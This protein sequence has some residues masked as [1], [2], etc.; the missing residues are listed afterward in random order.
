M[1][2]LT[3]SIVTPSFNQVDYIEDTIKSV[4]FQDHPNIEHIIMD[5]GSNDGTIDVLREYEGEY[6]MTWVSQADKG[7]ADAINK[8]FEK[9]SGD[10]LGWLNSDDVYLSKSVIS[11]SVEVLERYPSAD[12]VNG[13]GIRL[14]EDGKW[15]YPIK[16]RDHKLSHSDLKQVASVLQP[17]TFWY[18]YVWESIGIDDGLEYTFD[19]DFF[20]K[21]TR[22]YNLVPIPDYLIGY[23]WQGNNKTT[24][25]GMKRAEEIREITG[26]YLGHSS[27]QY[28]LLCLYCGIY[29]VSNHLPRFMGEPIEEA[30]DFFSS[31]VSYLS[32]KQVSGV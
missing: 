4:K 3:V 27:W 31:A 24:T 8:G 6:N 16:R 26:K 21:A 11:H 17:A 9:A 14:K 10:V 20:I 23:R 5:G 30:L 22:Y 19:W 15:D 25:G 12:L 32:L 1:S 7:Q 29:T 28:H 2:N 13:R 18:D